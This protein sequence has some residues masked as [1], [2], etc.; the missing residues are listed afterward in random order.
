[1]EKENFLVASVDRSDLKKA[2]YAF[3]VDA[4]V[5]QKIAERMSETITSMNFWESL[6]DACDKFGVQ[7]IGNPDN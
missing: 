5:M 7:Y 6:A 1:M 3:N 2:G 4:S